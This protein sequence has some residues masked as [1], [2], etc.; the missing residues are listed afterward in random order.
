MTQHYPNSVQN[1]CKAQAILVA[2]GHRWVRFVLDRFGT[3]P[4][5]LHLQHK[6]RA[7][8]ACGLRNTAL[9]GYHIYYQWGPRGSDFACLTVHGVSKAC[10]R[11]GFVVRGP[12]LC[13][14]SRGPRGS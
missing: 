9:H 12:S 3:D 5:G 10:A 4:L 2:P 13:A 6:A 1:S 7:S 8:R 11:P 14:W